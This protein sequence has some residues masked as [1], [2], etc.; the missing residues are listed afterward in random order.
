MTK[1]EKHL[2]LVTGANRGIG[3][4]VCRQLARLD[5]QVVLT[6]RDPAK[7]QAAA[8]GLADEGLP[9]VFHPLDVTDEAGIQ[10]TFRFV[11]GQYGRLDA[12]VNNAGISVDGDRSVMDLSLDVL[13][14][15][16]AAN[17]FG[18][19][20]MCQVFIPL[21]K[22]HHYG[23][24]VNVSSTM[25]QHAR[26]RN[27]SAAYRLSKDALN[28][29]TQMIADSIHTGDVLVNACHPGW[30]RTDMGGRNAP[31]PVEQ[32]ADTIVW[33]ATLPEGGPSGGFFENRRAIPW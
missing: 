32:G 11:A 3:F 17:T 6:G 8:R 2:A 21:M 19:L 13:Q 7:G 10:A 20:R 33:L 24:V 18:A 9:V 5:Y 29:L 12:L 4:E 28:A 16:L 23:R 27:M 31:V 15:T 25:G 14:R 26:M 30:V 22:K 1:N